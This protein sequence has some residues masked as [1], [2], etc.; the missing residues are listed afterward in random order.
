[1][2]VN[3]RTEQGTR[4]K[5]ADGDAQPVF[6]VRARCALGGLRHFAVIS[7]INKKSEPVS[8]LENL[9]RMI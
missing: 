5:Q 8:D 7:N 9:V 1:M 4:K 2:Q 3:D 6:C